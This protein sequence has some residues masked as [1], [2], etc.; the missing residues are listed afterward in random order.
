MTHQVVVS[1]LTLL[2]GGVD[3]QGEVHLPL[4]LVRQQE[5]PRKDPE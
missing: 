5:E 3:V 1:R 4:V 2:D